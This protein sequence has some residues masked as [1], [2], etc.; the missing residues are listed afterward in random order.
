ML[1]DWAKRRSG[2]RV[3]QP[4]PDRRLKSRPARARQARRGATGPVIRAAMSGRGIACW[5]EKGM[6]GFYQAPPRRESL[7]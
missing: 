3:G 6:A 1:R 2:G 7:P 5:D 4:D